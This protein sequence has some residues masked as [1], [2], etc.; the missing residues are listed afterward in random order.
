MGKGMRWMWE[1]S[2]KEIND[3]GKEVMVPKLS[4]TPVE[5]GKMIKVMYIVDKTKKSLDND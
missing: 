3:K 2:E 1:Y 5:N 4:L